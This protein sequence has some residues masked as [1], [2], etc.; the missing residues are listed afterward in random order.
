[1]Q[2]FQRLEP[3]NNVIATGRFVLSTKLVLGNVVEGIV[4]DRTG[5][6]GLTDAQL[7]NI[8]I[9]LNGK[10]AI[11]PINAAQLRLVE[12][13]LTG[14]NNANLLTLWFTEPRASTKADQ[15]IGA[16]DTLAAGVVDFTIEGDITGATTPVLNA[17]AIMRTPESYRQAAPAGTAA[18]IRALIQT[19]LSPSAAGEFSYDL[20]YGARG[21]SLIKRALFFGTTMTN[22]R[23]KRDTY[24]IYGNAAIP[25][26]VTNYL[27]TLYGETPQT[28]LLIFDP[29]TD[30][31][32]SDALPTRT[33]LAN[34]NSREAVYQWLL[35][36]SGAGVVTAYTDVYTTL[37]RL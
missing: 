26:A 22:L 25:N 14:V 1:M 15:L 12:T 13:Y 16:V 7:T 20:N 32:Q 28:N 6:G 27:A 4:L 17:Y 9:K 23:V 2:L 8:V 35:T 3:I 18:F 37:D 33:Q 30:G 31:H 10:N 29:L 11:G 21:E 24:D 19:T 5:S 36:V 34:G